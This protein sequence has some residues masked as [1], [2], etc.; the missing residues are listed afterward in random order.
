MKNRSLIYNVAVSAIAAVFLIGCSSYGQFRYQG[1]NAGDVTIETLVER[2]A[3]YHIYY[4]GYGVDNATGILFDPKND[5][6]T[7]NPSS[8]WVMVEDQKTA[9]DLVAWLKSQA[10]SRYYPGLFT[11]TGNA[12]LV[13]GYLYSGW[14]SRAVA[15]VV[16]DNTLFVFDLD[17]PP[18]YRGPNDDNMRTPS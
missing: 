9:E 12:G 14:D 16:D 11:V 3:D 8:R 18:H 4:S 7:L 15:K 10:E 13:Y 1:K 6:K 5:T 17:E 2:W